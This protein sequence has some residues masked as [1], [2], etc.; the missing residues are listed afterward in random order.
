MIKP[1]AVREAAKYVEDGWYVLVI[2]RRP[3]KLQKYIDSTENVFL[4]QDL[5]PSDELMGIVDEFKKRDIWN[6][7][8]FDRYFVKRFLLEILKNEKAKA[9]LSRISKASKAGKK[10]AIACFCG[11]EKMCHRSIIVGLLE[12]VGNEFEGF[13]YSPYMLDYLI[14]EHALKQ[15]KEK[16]NAG[17]IR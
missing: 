3:S 8:N 4:I 7:E 14:Y 9:M 16:E 10:F 6:Q 12:G 15:Q 5:A 2:V 13:D 11:D 17:Q 1:I